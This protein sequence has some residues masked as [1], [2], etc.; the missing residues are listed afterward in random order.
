VIECWRLGQ[1][2][3][4][5]AVNFAA[6]MA[7]TMVRDFID[8]LKL[9]SSPAYWN[10]DGWSIAEAASQDAGRVSAIILTVIAAIIGVALPNEKFH[11]LRATFLYA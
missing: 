2:G 10:G 8:P 4:S 1:Q 5:V 9:G 7:A 3:T 6:N 11:T